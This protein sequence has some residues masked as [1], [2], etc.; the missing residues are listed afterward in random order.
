MKDKKPSENQMTYLP[1]GMCLGIS[2]GT[3]IGVVTDNLA[4]G[5]CFGVSSGM[6]VGSLIDAKNRKKAEE[7]TAVEDEEEKEVEKDEKQ[8]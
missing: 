6:C 1:I 4:L 7:T 5:M 8:E 3:A 2:I